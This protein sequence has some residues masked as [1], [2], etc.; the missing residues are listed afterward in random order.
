VAVG[1]RIV[2]NQAAIEELLHS[3]A[4]PVAA[5]L[6]DVTQRVTQTAKRN[7][8]VGVPSHTPEGHPAGYLRSQ[9]GWSL[10]PGHDLVTRVYSP[11]RTSRASVVPNEPYGLYNEVPRLQPRGLP[12]HLRAKEGPYLVPAL[13]EVFNGL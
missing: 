1:G 12:A 6:V 13:N 2:V 5:F 4:G 11:A 9:I 3:P 10:I 8:P 7:A